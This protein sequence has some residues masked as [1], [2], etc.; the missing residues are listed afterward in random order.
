MESKLD[1]QVVDRFAIGGLARAR[2]REGGNVIERIGLTGCCR[3]SRAL[4]VLKQEKGPGKRDFMVSGI[5][6]VSKS[7]GLFIP[8]P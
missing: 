8:E 2:S 1:V 6:E 5:I 7:N 4:Q 3:I